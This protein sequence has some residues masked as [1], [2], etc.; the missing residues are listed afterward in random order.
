MMRWSRLRREIG[1]GKDVAPWHGPPG[2]GCNVSTRSTG[3][4]GQAAVPATC[5]EL[6]QGLI[7][8]QTCLVSCPIDRHSRA[9]VTVEEDGRRWRSRQPISKTL[10]ALD[11]AAEAWEYVAAGWVEIDSTIPRSRGYGSSTAD[12]G[13]GLF[14]LARAAGQ[15][16]EPAQAAQIAAEIEPTDS[17]LFPGLALFAHRAGRLLR[18]LGPAPDLGVLVI[19]PGG[20]VDT[21]AYNREITP[22][23]LQRLAGAHRE[24]FDWLAAGLAERDWALVGRGAT[25]SACA[26]QAILFSSWLDAALEACRALG[27]LGVCRA[28]SGTILGVLF[29]PDRLPPE[30][31][32]RRGRTLLPE[33]LTV[34]PHCLVGGGAR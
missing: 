18:P 9:R 20:Q 24:A 29:D 14:A 16:L 15:P 6:F 3:L 34:R 1:F 2:Q 7:D 4:E 8:G 13:A 25:L 17:S 30:E 31:A 11:R 26:H 28:H 21:V 32:L 27:G 5:G 22:G 19:D 12:I 33:S 23:A 10:A